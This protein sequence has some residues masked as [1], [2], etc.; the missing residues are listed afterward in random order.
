MQRLGKG[1]IVRLGKLLLFFS[2]Q[3]SSYT[4][5][6]CPSYLE[7][8]LLLLCLL[9]IHACGRHA[10]M[11]INLQGLR[12]VSSISTCLNVFVSRM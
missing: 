6:L 12:C 4:S 1:S 5:Q 3:M 8:V 7:E 2:L 11:L 10:D 9:H